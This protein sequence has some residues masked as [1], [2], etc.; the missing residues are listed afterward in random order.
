[1][2]RV[3]LPKITLHLFF[4]SNDLWMFRAGVVLFLFNLFIII[5]F[6]GNNFNCSEERILSPF[7]CVNWWSG[8]KSKPLDLPLLEVRYLTSVRYLTLI[9]H[10]CPWW[11][12]TWLLR[13]TL[14]DVQVNSTI[15]QRNCGLLTRLYIQNCGEFFVSLKLNVWQ[16]T[17]PV[18][19]HIDVMPAN[20]VVRLPIAPFDGL[21]CH[22][23][24]AQESKSCYSC[25]TPWCWLYQAL[26]LMYLHLTGSKTQCAQTHR[27]YCTPRFRE[28]STQQ[29]VCLDL[30]S[31]NNW[32]VLG[33]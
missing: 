11:R 17:R 27:M 2:I 31:S 4:V 6:S 28:Q 26:W 23:T 19:H 24:Y 5:Y 9:S 20:V 25:T 10:T 14:S 1:M 7:F 33:G 32:S 29:R 22:Q 21:C 3:E 8:L 13:I 16:A 30:L 12:S 18:E 15:R